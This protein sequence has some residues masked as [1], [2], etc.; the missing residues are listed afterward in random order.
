MLTKEEV[1]RI[2]DSSSNL[3]QEITENI[4]QNRIAQAQIPVTIDDFYSI[5]QQEFPDINQFKENEPDL[6]DN[7]QKWCDT[8]NT[9]RETYLRTGDYKHWALFWELVPVGYIYD[10]DY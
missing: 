10:N 9:I 1:N 4:M 2:I 7:I 8:L 3:D 5:I 6:I